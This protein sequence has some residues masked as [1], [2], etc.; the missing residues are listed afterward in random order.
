MLH[1]IG[2]GIGGQLAHILFSYVASRLSKKN[3]TTSV[4][5]ALE[6][7]LFPH[8]LNALAA[9]SASAVPC[10]GQLGCSPKP[11]IVAISLWK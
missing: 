11:A 3:G 1:L 8:I 6:T 4:T 9:A 7:V 2:A 5:P 10:L